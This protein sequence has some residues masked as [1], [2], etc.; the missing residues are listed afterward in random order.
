[1]T[2]GVHVSKR[3]GVH[4]SDQNTKRG[5]VDTLK[6]LAFLVRVHVSMCLCVCVRMC[7]RR[8]YKAGLYGYLKTPWTR[9]HVDTESIGHNNRSDVT[10]ECK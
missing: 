2:F 5:H 10:K 4:V 3:F 6:S 8:V 9:T 7:A 1:M